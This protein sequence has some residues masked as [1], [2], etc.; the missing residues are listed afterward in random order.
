MRLLTSFVIAAVFCCAATSDQADVVRH[1]NAGPEDII[2]LHTSTFVYSAIVL[3]EGEKAVTYLCGD[4]K[5]WD[6]QI[7][8]G[9]ERFVN[10]KP[11]PGAHATD[12]QILTDHNHAYTVKAQIDAPVDVKLFLDSTDPESIR[13]PPSFITVSEAQQ[14]K[15]KADQAQASPVITLK[16]PRP[17]ACGA[18]IPLG[19]R[20]RLFGEPFSVTVKIWFGSDETTMVPVCG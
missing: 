4:P 5:H 3:P 18:V 13:K 8:E 2:P 20:L 11:T 7:I 17:P 6:V 12:L 16:R 10:V 9:S 14:W 15:A 1:A 19:E